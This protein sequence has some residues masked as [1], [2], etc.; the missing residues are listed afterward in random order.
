MIAFTAAGTGEYSRVGRRA[1]PADPLLGSSEAAFFSRLKSRIAVRPPRRR[2]E[3][4]FKSRLMGV[5]TCGRDQW[6]TTGPGL[7]WCSA[8]RRF[9]KNEIVKRRGEVEGVGEITIPL[10][11][12]GRLGCSGELPPLH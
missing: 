1:L 8:V 5:G 11:S 10:T 12:T 2:T 9:L 7:F 6:R 3:A 4:L